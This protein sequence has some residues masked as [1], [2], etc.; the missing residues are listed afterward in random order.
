MKIIAVFHGAKVECLETVRQEIG[1][2]PPMTV[3]GMG[4]ILELVP[5]IKAWGPFQAAYCSLVARAMCTM[6]VLAMAL[7]IKQVA[8][9]QELGQFGNLDQGRVIPYP[10]HES[11]DELTWQWNGKL[12][13]VRIW[14]AC[15]KYGL[16]QNVLL[17]SHRPII[18]ALVALRDGITD[19]KGIAK[20]VASPDLTKDGYVIFKMNGPYLEPT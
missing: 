15:G 12:A 8:C 6:S 9:I 7:G 4:Q 16:A 18:G 11:D 20:I 19:K 17:V 2:N 13:W 3:P 1:A 14:D 5:T 10:G